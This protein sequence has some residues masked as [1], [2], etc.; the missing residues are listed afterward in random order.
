MERQQ[1]EDNDTLHIATMV[2][3]AVHAYLAQVSDLYLE[4]SKILISQII[5]RMERRC[6][7][8]VHRA[9]Y[10]AYNVRS[11]WRERYGAILQT[12]FGRLSYTIMLPGRPTN[13]FIVVNDLRLM[14]L[15]ETG[16]FLD[17]NAGSEEA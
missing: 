14:G 4:P 15:V 12:L 10:N 6:A 5:R 1:Q 13:P 7:E 16:A 17:L 9:V 3:V 2:F 8:V 11:Q